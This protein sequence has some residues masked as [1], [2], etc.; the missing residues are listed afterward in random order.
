MGSDDKLGMVKRTLKMLTQELRDGDTVAIATYAGSTK[1]VLEPTS[2]NQP[3]TIISALSRL[4]SGGGTAMDSGITLAYQL[5]DSAYISGAVNRVIVCSDGD[6]NVGRTNPAELTSTIQGYAERGV[7][8]TTLGYG[9][10]NYNDTMMERLANDGDGNYYYID[11]IRESRRLFVDQLSSTMEVIA[12]DVK[13][14]VDW[15]SDHVRAYR[16]IG[17]ENRDIADRD[18]R[19]DKV[20]AG[21]IGAGHQVTAL[22][23]VQFERG[24]PAAGDIAT[25]RIRNKAPGPDAPATE[26][27]YPL[28]SSAFR[29]SFGEGSDD[30]RIA[31]AAASFAEILRGSPHTQELSLRQVAEMAR[32]A[33]R[34]EIPDDIEL[35][36]LIERAAELKGDAIAAR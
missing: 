16:L 19:D 34:A 8:L 28:A 21:E 31:I 7:T 2:V 33:A 17:Y 29:S 18:F 6:A 22:Y 5:A 11:S 23:E 3:G 9:A 30:V 24:V 1:I 12:K 4:T 15:S 13:I 32:G 36:S 10:G 27:S 26:R 35:I 20:D 14:Q 25:V